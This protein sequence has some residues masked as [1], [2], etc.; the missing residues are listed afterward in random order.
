[1]NLFF[2]SHM[3]GLDY[4]RLLNKNLL[5]TTAAQIKKQSMPQNEQFGIVGKGARK[6][7]APSL[8]TYFC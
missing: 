3:T 1:M 4:C 6:E 2:F 8:V 7:W 5:F